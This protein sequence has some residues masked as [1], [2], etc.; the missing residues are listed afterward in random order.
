LY[1]EFAVSFC[2]LP[3]KTEQEWRDVWALPFEQMIATL[4][5]LSEGEVKDVCAILREQTKDIVL[6]PIGGS[7]NALGWLNDAGVPVA[8]VTSRKGRLYDRLEG[9][10]YNRDQF[11]QIVDANH[12]PCK[13]HRAAFEPVEAWAD[14]NLSAQPWFVYIDDNTT[15]WHFALNARIDFWAVCTG[16][17][18][19]QDW[20]T[21]GLPQHL[22]FSNFAA[23][24]DH[25]LRIFIP[26]NQCALYAASK[27]GQTKYPEISRFINRGQFL[28]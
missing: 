1:Q 20:I 8:L 24:I 12:Q 22:I 15:G 6:P 10:G 14:E 11:V 18:K 4:F 26:Q 13:P 9:A 27:C 23:A 7:L 5:C 21:A 2:D 17:M 19:R 28:I 16:V 25:L 3:K